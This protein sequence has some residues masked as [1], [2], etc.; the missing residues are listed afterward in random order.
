M[1]EPT[2]PKLIVPGQTASTDPKQLYVTN[3]SGAVQQEITVKPRPTGKVGTR[4]D[5]GGFK[6]LIEGINKSSTPIRT[7]LAVSGLG[8]VGLALLA[9]AVM[10][11]GNPFLFADRRD[12]WKELAG[13][14]E[15]NRS[16]VWRSYFDDISP[17]WQG[18]APTVLQQ[19]IRFNVNGLY[20]QLG[21][22]SD[23]MS[24]TMQGQYKEVIEYD[25][26]L[27]GLLATSK[28]MFEVLTK[29]STHPAG[30]LALMAQAGAFL[31]AL[32]NLIKQFSDVYSSYEGDLNKL[33]LKLN[34]LKGAFYQSGDPG[35][36]PRDL[37]L[38]SPIDDPAHINDNWKPAP[39]LEGKDT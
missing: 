18:A 30:R 27:L 12:T 38:N 11:A 36:G 26:S 28:P 25:L 24:G 1:T 9:A 15:G 16:D 39:H 37:N 6:Q 22:I 13:L 5:P 4:T 21:K 23:E 7:G 14:L 32:A 31:G 2:P 19:Y 29:M 10:N 33:E 8:V 17:N 35:R 3:A 20:S 34:D